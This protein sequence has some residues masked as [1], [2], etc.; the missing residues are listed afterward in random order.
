[1]AKETALR[2]QISTSPAGEFCP[3][4]VLC[5]E[6]RGLRHFSCMYYDICLNKAAKGMWTGFTCAEC[7]FFEKREPEAP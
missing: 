6:G 4:P 7:F 2:A 5:R 1:M 3:D